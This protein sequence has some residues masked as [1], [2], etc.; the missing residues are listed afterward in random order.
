MIA[1][2]SVIIL[3]STAHG[4]LSRWGMGWGVWPY[5]PMHNAW[6]MYG[7][8]WSP[9]PWYGYSLSYYPMSTYGAKS[10]YDNY[11]YNTP[12]NKLGYFTLPRWNGIF[13]K[14]I[15]NYDYSNQMYAHPHRPMGAPLF[16]SEVHGYTYGPEI[17]S[18][19]GG[20]YGAGPRFYPYRVNTNVDDFGF[21]SRGLWNFPPVNFDFGYGPQT[22]NSV[23]PMYSAND[24]SEYGDGSDEEREESNAGN[25]EDNYD[26]S[27]YNQNEKNSG[28]R[29]DDYGDQRRTRRPI[30]VTL[31]R[32][33][34]SVVRGK[35]KLAYTEKGKND[36]EEGKRELS[37]K[38]ALIHRY[39]AEVDTLGYD[40]NGYGYGKANWAR[41]RSSPVPN[42]VK[43]ESHY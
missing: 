21:R 40:K 23:P 43:P 33:K 13:P 38:Y 36:E 15:N 2:L 18:Y 24:I 8:H 20:G 29:M 25:Y 5:Y 6:M 32:A 37:K 34:K 3:A 4:Q 26:D 22:F 31:A 35:N 14:F 10:A 19:G 41:S 27:A 11:S 28:E 16:S 39:N 12:Y 1:C 42:W 7:P 17:S 30:P 9:T